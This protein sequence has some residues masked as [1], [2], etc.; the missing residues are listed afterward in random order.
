MIVEKFIRVECSEC[1]AAFSVVE[2]DMD[3]TKYVISNC[4]YCG[5]PGVESFAEETPAE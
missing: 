2:G 3:E 4:I 1:G 5:E